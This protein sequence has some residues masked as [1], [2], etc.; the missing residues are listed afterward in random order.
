MKQIVENYRQY[1]DFLSQLDK[2]SMLYHAFNAVRTRY[3][4][5]GHNMLK[6]SWFTFRVLFKKTIVAMFQETYLTRNDMKIAILGGGSVNRI[7]SNR[8]GIPYVELAFRPTMNFF[9]NLTLPFMVIRLGLAIRKSKLN[10]PYVNQLIF[11]MIEF[12]QVYQKISYGD[13]RCVIFENSVYPIYYA[14]IQTAMQR[15]I[16]TIKIDY[17][18]IDDV[19]FN[20]LNAD[21]YFYPNEYHRKLV[22]GF[23]YNKHINYVKGGFP[24]WDELYDYRPGDGSESRNLVTF[25]TQPYSPHPEIKK[26]HQYLEDIIECMKGRNDLQLVIR[27]HP[28]DDTDYSSYLNDKVKISKSQDDNPYKLIRNSMCTFSIFST[29]TL[30]SKHLCKNSFFINYDPKHHKLPVNYGAF[31]GYLDLID[32]KENLAKVFDGTFITSS[33]D[34][35]IEGFNPTFPNTCQALKTLAEQN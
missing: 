14:M 21:T 8:T 34:N 17:Y 27:V 18:F 30:E 31:D 12:L 5:H 13:V 25:F 1:D 9:K 4:L 3:G 32:N 22:S 19:F 6:K 16:K 23:P 29:I 15:N 35:F 28:A 10:K 2:N 26:T 33:I 24:H 7:I 20:N 11:E